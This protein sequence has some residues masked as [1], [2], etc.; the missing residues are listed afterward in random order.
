MDLVYKIYSVYLYDNQLDHDFIILYNRTKNYYNGELSWDA[1]YHYSDSLKEIYNLTESERDIKS[2]SLMRLAEVR[3]NRTMVNELKKNSILV[4]NNGFLTIQKIFGTHLPNYNAYDI[5]WN[6]T[7]S[8]INI[9]DWEVAGIW[10]I[11]KPHYSSYRIWEE[12]SERDKVILDSK[13]NQLL[14]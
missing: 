9:H 12:K 6:E 5:F 7:K 4:R 8:G 3:S 13:L 1:P 2:I 10:N 11:G 14:F